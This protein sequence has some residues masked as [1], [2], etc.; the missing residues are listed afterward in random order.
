MIA[1]RIAGTILERLDRKLAILG[2]SMSKADIFIVDDQGPEATAMLQALYSRSGASAREHLKQVQE[3]GSAKFM[4]SFYVGYGHASI[5][6]CG[7]TTFFVEGLSI[8]A[9]KAVQD[10]P[11]YSGQESSTRYIDFSKQAII[12]P[13]KTPQSKEI[14]DAWMDFYLSRLAPLEAH[15]KELFPLAEGNGCGTMP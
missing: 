10:N 5:G 11:L 3:R 8:L 13:I 12:D 14:L 15:L 4:E 2:G 9:C 6:D 7:S 1:S